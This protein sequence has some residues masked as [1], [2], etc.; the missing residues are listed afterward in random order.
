MTA[1]LISMS[2]AALVVVAGVPGSGTTGR[3][4]IARSGDAGLG[5]DAALGGV[6]LLGPARARLAS[7]EGT[8]SSGLMEAAL[9]LP[10]IGDAGDSLEARGN[11]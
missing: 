11:R 2:L 5:V 3:G 4:C 7:C 9:R 10:S 1:S 8:V 6:A